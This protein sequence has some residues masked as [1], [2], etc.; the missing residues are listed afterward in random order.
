VEDPVGSWRLRSVYFV[1]QRTGNRLDLLGGEP[2][3]YTLIEPGGRL[4]ALLT[5]DGR[6]RAEVDDV[7]ALHTSM[8]AYTGRW[9]IEGETVVTRVDGAWDPSWV[10]TEQ[11]RH[12]EFGEDTFSLR[13]EPFSHPAIP[14]ES[15]VSYAEFERETRAEGP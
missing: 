15:V 13:S 3:G 2:F 1:A 7:A 9:S 10:G 11:V 12:L 8:V 6:T 4:M 14:G 5:A